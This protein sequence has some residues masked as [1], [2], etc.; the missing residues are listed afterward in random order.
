MKIVIAMD[1]FKGTLSSLAAGEA[2]KEGFLTVF[3]DTAADVVCVADGGEGMTDAMMRNMGGKIFSETV[4]GPLGEPV[5]AHW[6]MAGDVAVIEMAAAA[7]LPLLEGK[8]RAPCRS[9]T[10]GVGEL[11]KCALSAGAG[12]IIVG[13]GG[14]ATNDGGAGMAQALGIRFRDR[15]GNELEPGGLA[16]RDLEEIDKKGMDPRLANCTVIAACDVTNPLCGP[17]GATYVYGPQKG[18]N[19]GTAEK[20]DGAL[21]HFSEVVRLKTGKDFAKLPGAGAAGGLGFGLMAL[22]NARVQPGIETVLASAGME[23]RVQT[24]DLVVTG[25]GTMD[26]QTVN[27]KTP[28]GVAAYAKLCRVPVLAVAGQL[29]PGY[30]KVYSAG[31]DAAISCVSEIK[32]WEEVKTD[33]RGALVRAAQNAAR[34]LRTGQMISVPAAVFKR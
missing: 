27:G 34:F 32:P 31:I 8:L 19:E 13:L 18:V 11:I 23:K 9:T 21:R 29:K 14:S 33:A 2:V 16:L 4:S 20:L 5:Q 25:E 30:E 17:N 6:G 7:G 26:G 1:S 12:T 15:N 3:P 10:Y 24:A 28:V 22:L